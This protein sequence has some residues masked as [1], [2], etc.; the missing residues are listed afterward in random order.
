MDIVDLFWVIVTQLGED[1]FYIVVLSIVYLSIDRKMGAKMSTIVLLNMSVNAIAKDFFKMPRPPPELWKYPVEGYGFPS[2]HAQGSVVM[3]GYM[4][5][6]FNSVA[7]AFLSLIL[8]LL[9]SY[10]RIALQV[11]Y[12]RDIIGGWGIGGAVLITGI[13]VDRMGIPS[14]LRKWKRQLWLALPVGFFLFSLATGL[15]TLV[16]AITN[17]VLLGMLI[18]YFLSEDS[19]FRQP[20][21]WREKIATSF[22]SIV[23]FSAF[24]FEVIRPIQSIALLFLASAILGSIGSY[25]VP[26]LG[27]KYF[28]RHS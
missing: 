3:W 24:Y 27:D 8:V 21:G 9:V 20:E 14:R 2:G 5:Y 4:S 15:G 10:S 26:F 19:R 23:L 28:A 16:S 7:L 1:I 11:H 25:F 13:A 12:V 22:A 18:G 6:S 17:G